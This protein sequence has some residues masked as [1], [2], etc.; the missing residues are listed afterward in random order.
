M[1]RIH[2]CGDGYHCHGSGGVAGYH[3]CVKSVCKPPGDAALIVPQCFTVP[4]RDSVEMVEVSKTSTE[5]RLF[6]ALPLYAGVPITSADSFVIL[7]FFQASNGR[8]GMLFDEIVIISLVNVLH[9]I[10]YHSRHAVDDQVLAV[11]VSFIILLKLI[12]PV[13][14]DVFMG[15]V[16]SKVS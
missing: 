5:F 15:F 13:W 14:I 11:F 7:L 8:H 16:P 4:R 2:S 3:D 10:C 6:P 9:Q 1:V 12:S